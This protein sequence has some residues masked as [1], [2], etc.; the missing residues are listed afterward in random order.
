MIVLL[1]LEPRPARG[2][3]GGLVERSVLC[4]VN[5][6]DLKVPLKQLVFCRYSHPR[7]VYLV[8]F[9]PHLGLKLFVAI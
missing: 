3:G 8:E 7:G 9:T 4:V 5:C 6:I 2:G 1:S